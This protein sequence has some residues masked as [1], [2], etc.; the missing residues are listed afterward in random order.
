[1]LPAGASNKIEY[2]VLD[3]RVTD[4]PITNNFNLNY[5]KFNKCNSLFKWYTINTY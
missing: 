1:M 5:T 2:T 3:S 4:Y